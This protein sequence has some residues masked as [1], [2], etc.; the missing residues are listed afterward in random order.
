MEADVLPRIAA[1]DTPAV[2]TCIDRYGGLVWSLARRYLGDTAD[3]EDAVQE[4][5]IA[6]W[7]SAGRFDRA[8]APEATFVAMITRRKLIDRL[9]RQPRRRPAGRVVSAQ[10]IEARLADPGHTPGRLD[11]ALDLQRVARALAELGAAQREAILLSLAHG[12]SH[13]QVADATGQPLGTVK[14]HIRRGL[15]K[16]RTLLHPAAGAPGVEAGP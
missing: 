12:L 3:A 2:R 16:L 10:A 6:L 15:V 13:Q 5:F 14:A 11:A 4:V 8:V 9:R 1:G 7:E